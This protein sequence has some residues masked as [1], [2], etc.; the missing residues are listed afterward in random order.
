[1]FGFYFKTWKFFDCPERIGDS[2]PSKNAYFKWKKIKQRLHCIGVRC[3]SLFFFNSIQFPSRGEVCN[4][5]Q[6]RTSLEVRCFPKNNIHVE[7]LE[8]V[9]QYSKLSVFLYTIHPFFCANFIA[10]QFSVACNSYAACGQ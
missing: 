7:T 1:M 8:T 2:R 10:V 9:K 6:R 3:S 4:V 5:E